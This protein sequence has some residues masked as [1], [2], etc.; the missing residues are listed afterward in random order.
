[1]RRNTYF[2]SDL[3]L[4]ANYIKNPRQHELRITSWLESISGDA[5]TLFLLGDVLDYWYEYRSVVPR[6][7]IRFFGTLARMA[8]QGV[9]IVWLK[10]NHDIWLFDYLRNE[11]GL[12]VV[13]GIL[14]R[15]IDGKIFLMEHGDGVG[16]IP[17]AYK[18]MRSTFRNPFAQWLYAA[19]HP[20]WTMAFAHGWSNNSRKS[21]PTPSA[22]NVS[23]DVQRL[24]SFAEHTLVNGKHVD[25]FVFGHLHTPFHT[26]LCHGKA[27]LEILGD[28]F[29]QFDYGMWNGHEFHHGTMPEIKS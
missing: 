11:I 15:E 12:Q 26:D 29:S 14:E 28:C 8:D 23:H 20:R 19:I 21:Q 17:T 2:I 9:E 7:F 6:G 1:M 25:Y 10:G 5:R 22:H 13:D 18:L 4:G 27:H 24:K 3:H 16:K